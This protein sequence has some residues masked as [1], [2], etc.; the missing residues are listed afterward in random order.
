MARRLAPCLVL[1]L[2]AAVYLWQARS[3]ADPTSRQAPT[4]YGFAMLGLCALLSVRILLRRATTQDTGRSKYHPESK[5]GSASPVR[6]L[7]MIAIIA[8]CTVMIYVTGFYVATAVFLLLFMTFVSK[9]RLLE[10]ASIAI[11]APA[12]IWL[13]LGRL[14]NLSV[15]SGEIGRLLGYS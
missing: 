11:L 8:T 4:L 6:A 2:V 10:S 1:A 15:Y 14:L 9:L 7:A 3:F 13:C 5:S 12:M